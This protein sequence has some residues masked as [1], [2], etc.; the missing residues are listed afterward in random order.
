[1]GKIS[2]ISSLI[3]F[4]SIIFL[5]GG[6]GTV[7]KNTT[8]SNSDKVFDAEKTAAVTTEQI[9]LDN[10]VNK[11][12]RDILYIYNVEPGALVEIYKSNVPSD[13]KF[14]GSGTANSIGYASV[15]LTSVD[16][17]EDCLIYIFVTAQGKQRSNA[18]FINKFDSASYIQLL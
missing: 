7:T 16:V 5:L 10:Y 1:M 6:C 12:I 8:D 14:I 2:K 17:G 4:S 13:S 9:T 11:P 18:L 15:Q 3:V